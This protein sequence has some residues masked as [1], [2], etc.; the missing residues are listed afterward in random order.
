MKLRGVYQIRNTSSGKLY[1]GSSEDVGRRLYVHKRMLAAGTHHSTALQR[2]WDKYGP[3]AFE[4]SLLRALPQGDL[5][6]AEQELIDSHNAAGEGGYNMCPVAGTRAGSKQ[7]PSVAENQSRRMKGVPKSP[8]H[9]AR[10]SA[11]R[12]G[13]PKS[14][15]HRAKL[16]DA[17]R[18]VMADPARRQHLAAMNTGRMHTPEA[19]LKIGE[20]SRRRNHHQEQPS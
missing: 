14:P 18:R 8:E 2:A 5:L 17:T 4:L 13:Q 15:E 9:R 16:A 7:P 20:A 10:I 12:K 1:V 3:G 11:G 19:K 6:A